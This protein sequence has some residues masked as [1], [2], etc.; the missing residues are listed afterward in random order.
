VQKGFS[1]IELLIVMAIISILASIAIP[2]LNDALLRS[3]IAS[4]TV[5]AKAV[6]LAFKQYNVDFSS[7]P[8][9]DAA[10]NFQLDSFEPLVSLGYYTGSMS[11]KLAS[12]Q[13][14]GYDSPDDQG[15]NQE[16]WLEFT[17]DYDSTIRYL[18]ADSDDAPLSGGDYFDG[19]FLYRDGVL[20]PLY[21]IK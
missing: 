6:Y 20:T 19:V 9:S 15:V 5:D 16:F 11:E 10:P 17:L 2:L 12:N 18:V 21:A 13:A 14:D 3:H 1:M 4:L 7:Y 8:N